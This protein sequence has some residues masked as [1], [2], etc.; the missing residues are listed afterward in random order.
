MYKGMIYLM[1]L[2]LCH[3]EAPNHFHDDPHSGLTTAYT[4]HIYVFNRSVTLQLCRH[5]DGLS[6]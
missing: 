3:I 6:N 4:Q 2:L 5:L 1:V